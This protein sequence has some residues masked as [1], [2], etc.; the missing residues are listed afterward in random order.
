MPR[1]KIPQSV[2]KAEGVYIF[3]NLDEEHTEEDFDKD[4]NLE[5]TYY[6]FSYTLLANNVVHA[7][8]KVETQCR[9]EHSYEGARV[10]VT[11]CEL[12][13]TLSDMD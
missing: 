7:C 1:P 5:E 2:Y 10:R 11:S 9:S 6:H 8:Q 13:G 12:L 3:Q 4:G